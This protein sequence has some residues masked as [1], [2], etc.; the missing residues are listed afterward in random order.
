MIEK[1]SLIRKSVEFSM[2]NQQILILLVASLVIFGVFALIKMPKQEFPVFSIR[3]GL[4]V[5]VYPGVSSETVEKQLTT[6]LEEFIYSYKEVDRSRTYSVTKD[7]MVVLFVQLNGEV[8]KSDDEFWSKFRHDVQQ[9]KQTLP[10]GVLAIATNNDF[11][12]TSALLISIESEDKTYRELEGYLNELEDELRKNS[13]VSN[14]RRYGIMNEQ[15]SVYLDKEKLIKY[16]IN[17]S[18]LYSTLVAQNF[19]TISGNMEKDDYSIPIHVSETYKSENDIAEQII[20]YDP[21]GGIIRLK[22]VANIA[23]EYPKPTSYIKDGTKKCVMLSIEMQD[24][25]NIVEYGNEVNAIID[26]FKAGLPDEVEVFKVAD[27]AS[28]VSHSVN[29]FLRE[30][31]IAILTVIGVIMLLQPMRVAAISAMTIPITM[32]I[33]LGILYF[34]G[35]EIN[36]VTLA[37]LLV[38]LGIIVD[39]SI[40]VIDNYVE[41]LDH[42][43]SR[44]EASVSSGT[45]LFKSIL[46]ATL[47]ITITFY[48]LLYTCTGLFGE[49]LQAFPGTITVTLFVSLF[50]AM[51]FIPFVQYAFIKKGFNEA[52]SQKKRKVNVADYIQRGYDKLIHL[53]FRFPKITI[54]VAF[55]AIVG[56]VLIF[57]FLP[58]KMMPVTERNQFVVEITLPSAASLEETAMVADSVENML[59]KDERIQ[60]ITSF[61]GTSAPRF[62][63]CYAPKFPSPQIAQ[64]IVTTESEKM[65]NIL[66]D[67]YVDKSINMIPNAYIRFKQLDYVVNP[68]PIEIRVMSENEDSLRVAKERIENELRKMDELLLVTNSVDE[69]LPGIAV[70]I[71]NVEANRLGITKPAVMAN[72]A[73]HYGNGL[74]ITTLWE[75][76]YPLS[77]VLKTTKDTS[78][79]F[80]GI[81]DEYINTLIGEAIPL[82]QVSNILPD[83]S[84]GQIERRN[85]VSSVTIGADVKRNVNINRVDKKISKVIENNVQIPD[86]VELTWG[87]GKEQDEILMPQIYQGLLF[88]V[89]IIF[90]IL[91]FHFKKISLTFLILGATLLSIF[92]AAL[93]IRVM[94]MEFTLTSV[95]GLVALMGIIVRNGIIMYDYAE[96]QRFV[97]HKSVYD[98][99]LEAGKRRMRPIFLTSAAASMGVVPM[100]I[101]QSALWSPMA[102]VICFGTWISMIFVVTVLPVLYWL[103]F[104]KADAKVEISA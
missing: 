60:N 30:M 99:A 71:D 88:S 42:G 39:D 94:G 32:F 26:E 61:V 50:I 95:L 101:S 12:K 75:E 73:L 86:Q 92:G 59:R 62:H 52:N 58:Q 81:S 54:L 33:S 68:Y 13:K 80:K 24:G 20:Y 78:T 74:P 100:I 40:V 41:K 10:S 14:L 25:N 23:R 65:T 4:V 3:Q 87:G 69:I 51:L 56:G 18:T 1:K 22:D 45:E 67:E 43:I 93:G 46:S 57:L 91:L 83:W 53:S 5:G 63:M 16:G 19:N 21:S 9:F 17:T 44:W 8:V 29:M 55:L 27:Q 98:A 37:A 104:K 70:N 85:G 11:G 103:V 77:V 28:V 64:L 36:T 15:I 38:V 89:L 82:R 76:D 6:P 102:V 47:A 90:I 96:E 35:Y 48:P 84:Q 66:L 72:L 2:K 49:F 97:H 34:M 7:G 79:G 31:L